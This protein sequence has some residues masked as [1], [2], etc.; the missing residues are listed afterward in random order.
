MFAMPANAHEVLTRQAADKR[1]LSRGSQNPL[2]EHAHARDPLPQRM[3]L[4]V[5]RVHLDFRQLG[6]AA[7]CT[8]AE[9]LA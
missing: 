5:A 3:T 6:H 7:K 8:M 1:R 9:W 4:E 2:I